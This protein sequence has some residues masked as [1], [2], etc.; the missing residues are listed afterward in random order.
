MK[1]RSKSLQIIVNDLNSLIEIEF[2]TK[3]LNILID[4]EICIKF[5]NTVNEVELCLNPVNY[6]E[7]CVGMSTNKFL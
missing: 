4:S 2:C 1:K 6:C 5:Q 7:C 3:C